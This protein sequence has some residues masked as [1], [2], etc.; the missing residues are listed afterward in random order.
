[1][2]PDIPG[3]FVSWSDGGSDDQ[4]YTVPTG[5]LGLTL[6]A[7]YE[8]PGKLQVDSVPSGLPFTVDGAACTTPCILLTKP[9]ERR[10]K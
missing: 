5:L 9:P 4:S 8:P 3:Q 6:T 10:C 7:T 2:R 1:M